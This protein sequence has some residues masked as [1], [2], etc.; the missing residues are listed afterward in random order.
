MSNSPK[1]DAASYLDD[2]RLQDPH[3]DGNI[4]SDDEDED[5]ITSYDRLAP[6]SPIKSFGNPS[7]SPAVMHP[8][9]SQFSTV[10]TVGTPTIIQA[11]QSLVTT[12]PSIIRDMRLAAAPYTTPVP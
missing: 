6:S 3:N 7:L 8:D 10:V 4:S 12:A 5:A 2:L 11:A 1:W 9:Q